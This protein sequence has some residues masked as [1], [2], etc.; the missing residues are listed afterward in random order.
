M[1]KDLKGWGFQQ[2]GELAQMVVCGTWKSEESQ[3]L[4]SLSS[5]GNILMLDFFS[6]LVIL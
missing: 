6:S 2:I 5:G 1:T 3:C 4:G